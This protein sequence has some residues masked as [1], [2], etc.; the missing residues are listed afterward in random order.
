MQSYSRK[1]TTAR[2]QSSLISIL[3]WQ[4]ISVYIHFLGTKTSFVLE[5]GVVLEST[6]NPATGKTIK[7]I[8]LITAVK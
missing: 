8:K 1:N 6:S 7:N 5:N 3:F 4:Y 2:A